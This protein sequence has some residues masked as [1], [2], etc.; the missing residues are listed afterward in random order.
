MI[1][2]AVDELRVP[3]LAHYLA[4]EWGCPIRDRM[5]QITY[6]EL[7]RTRRLPRGAWVFTA[8]EALTDAELKIVQ[9][10]QNAARDAGLP[11]LNQ[12]REAL[13]RYELLR[14][15][16]ERG[17]N[18]FCVY[19][20]DGPLDSIRFPVFVR[21]TEEHD[22]SLTPLLHNRGELR[23]AMVYL[24]LRGL[25]RHQLLVVEFCDT[26]SADG[27]YR[28][29]SIFR[30]GDAYVARHLHIGRDWVTKHRSRVNDQHLLEEE[31]TYLRDNPH[32]AWA[33]QVFEMAHTEYGRIDYG[34][35]QGRPQTWEI[36]FTPELTGDP[37]HVDKTPEEQRIRQVT[38]PAKAYAHAGLR[39]AFIGIDPGPIPGDDLHIDLPPVLEAEAREERSRVQS[40][41]RSQERISRLAAAPVLRKL[42]PLLRQTL[43]R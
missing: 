19:R 34:M 23:R 39:K 42:G 32:A 35:Y 10:M 6:P 29:Y 37:H 21:V 4:K 36:N 7:F 12:A 40:L 24:R 38:Y 13:R 31:M 41:V 30:I 11:V 28:K 8:L 16:H 33:R 3:L 2:F 20:A 9:H 15:L 18:S 14:L 5:R 26:V 25:R 22:G 27:L 1:Y 17:L 43:F